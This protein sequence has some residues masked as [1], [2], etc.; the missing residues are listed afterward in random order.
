MMHDV[1]AKDLHATRIQDPIAVAMGTV[2]GQRIAIIVKSIVVRRRFVVMEHA[3]Q[4]RTRA[5]VRVIVAPRPKLI[6]M[7]G[8][9]TIATD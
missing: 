2:M 7:M 9:I 8:L 1:P 5:A 3:I 4:V 6:A